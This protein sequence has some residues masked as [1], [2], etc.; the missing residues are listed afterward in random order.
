MFAFGKKMFPSCRAVC[1]GRR[2]AVRLSQEIAYGP[3][4]GILL[5]CFFNKSARGVTGI[6]FHSSLSSKVD[7]N[8]LKKSCTLG[9]RRSLN[10]Q[11]SSKIPLVFSPLTTVEMSTSAHKHLKLH[12]FGVLLTSCRD[13]RQTNA[14]RLVQMRPYY[15][16]QINSRKK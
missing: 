4:T 7:G 8:L 12:C 16:A 6:L 15:T 1:D 10:S 3:H 11:L 14:T 13:G 5:Q 9:I 2:R